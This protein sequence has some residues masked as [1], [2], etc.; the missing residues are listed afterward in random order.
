MLSMLEICQD[1]ADLLTVQKPDSLFDED[2]QH[3]AVFLSVAKRLL[4][5]FCVTATGR[6]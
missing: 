6:S 5:K 4:I 1:C 2:S 3:N